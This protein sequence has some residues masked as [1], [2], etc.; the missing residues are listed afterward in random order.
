MEGN[1]QSKVKKVVSVYVSFY[2]RLFKVISRVLSLILVAIMALG[3]LIMISEKA[4]F[5]N[6]SVYVVESESMLPTIKKGDAVIVNKEEV[7]SKGDIIT[8]YPVLGADKTYT[9]RIEEVNNSDGVEL[10]T[11][12]G[13]N[14]PAIDPFK[15][16]KEL[17]EGKVSQ[18]IPTIGELILFMRSVTGIILFIIIPSTILLTINLQS[19]YNWF[20][21]SYQDNKAY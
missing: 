6:F 16:K 8:F 10:F 12:K 4:S 18:I 2:Y 11:T 5:L 13:D 15:V 20:R 19:F 17:I 21:K 9:H 14:N 7:Y 3:L 1:K